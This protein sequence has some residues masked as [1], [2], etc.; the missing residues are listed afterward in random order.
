MD[1][2]KRNQDNGPE[3]NDPVLKITRNNM[4]IVITAA[5]IVLA[6]AGIIF[7]L[8]V[9][10]SPTEIAEDPE[11][12]APEEVVEDPQAEPENGTVIATINGEEVT[13]GEFNMALQQEM[14]QYEM[15]GIDMESDEMKETE[16]EIKEQVFENNFIIPILLE[17][18]SKE[19]GIEITDQEVEE[20][21]MEYETQFGGD[22]ALE[23]Q[24]EQMGLTREELEEEIALE[25]T[26]TSFLDQ[27]LDNY[28][29]EHP[30]E[31]I[32]EEKVEIDEEEVEEFYRQI[33]DAHAEINAML[34]E[35]DPEMPTEQAEMQLSQ[36]E[37]QYGH[38]LEAEDYEEARPMIE[39]EMRDDQLTKDRQEK[40]QRIFMEMIEDLKDDSDIEMLEDL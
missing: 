29:E 8:G 12:E 25:L 4:Y 38:I 22:E 31:R 30:D 27:Y 13:R 6:G 34:E 33:N 24:M 18:K 37:Q 14:A 2:E 28:L 5:V 36:I 9:F 26:V 21:Y 19:V 40:E 10:D 11:I 20:R 1:N 7:A 35:E 16:D 15:H 3:K 39:D 32:D 23:A 17:Q